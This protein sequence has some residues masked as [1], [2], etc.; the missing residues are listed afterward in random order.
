[1]PHGQG[2]RAL[3]FATTLTFIEQSLK[4]AVPFYPPAGVERRP[5]TMQER[6]R[7]GAEALKDVLV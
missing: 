6:K 1:M 2:G 5:V 7:I 3:E 4:L